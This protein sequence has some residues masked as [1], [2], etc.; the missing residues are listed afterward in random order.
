MTQVFVVSLTWHCNDFKQED[1]KSLF[2]QASKDY[3][4][5]WIF[6][7]EKGENGSVHVQGTWDLHKKDR[8]K[9]LALGLNDRLPGVEIRRCSNAG[10]EALRMYCMKANTRIAGPWM[11]PT[12]VEPYRGED[13]PEEKDLWPWQ[14]TMLEELRQ[15]ADK[16]TIHWIFDR[17]GNVGKST[18]TKYLDVHN[19]AESYELMALSDTKYQVIKDGPKKAYIFD[20]PRTKPK[21]IDMAELYAAMESIKNGKLKGGKYE[22]GKLNM[23]CP[24]VYVFANMPPAKA[25]MSQDRWKVREISEHTLDF[26]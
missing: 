15:P 10:R 21:T 2:E 11:D 12:Y 13:L 18:F 1:A 25:C 20:I 3:A 5:K 23:R 24:H 9:R 7:F 8:P 4:K 16:R 17:V 14:R 26:I 22:G 6:Q 19:I